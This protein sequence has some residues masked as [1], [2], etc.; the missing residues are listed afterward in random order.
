[1]PLS[2]HPTLSSLHCVHKSILYTCIST[3]ALQTGSS[4]PSSRFHICALTLTIW[5]FSFWLH[6]VWQT[7]GSSTS[8]LLTLRVGQF[9][10]EGPVQ[11]IT[12][13]SI[14]GLY[15]IAASSNAPSHDK[16]TCLQTFARGST[17]DK[18]A[19]GWALL[20]QRIEMLKFSLS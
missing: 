13:S 6:F 9:V 14:P 11:S 15:P 8:L 12:F 2:T 20:N 16:L 10:A 19:H 4:L 17:G 7:L 18:I 1:M 5:F 3:A